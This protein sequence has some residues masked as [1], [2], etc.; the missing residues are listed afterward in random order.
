MKCTVKIIL[1]FLPAFLS[2][3]TCLG[4]ENDIK[5]RIW[6][7]SSQEYIEVI[8][9]TVMLDDGHGPHI[10]YARIKK[11]TL[12]ICSLDILDD[13][14]RVNLYSAKFKIQ[15]LTRDT[16]IIKPINL[17]YTKDYFDDT[18]SILF[19]NKELLV[20]SNLIFQGLK[21]TGSGCLGNCPEYKIDIDANGLL[22]VEVGISKWVKKG[23]YKSQLSNKDLSKLLSILK[24]SNLDS[25]PE[26]LWGAIDAPIYSFEFRY[27]N[28][29]KKSNGSF[30]P[31]FNY[32]L[33]H[34]LYNI[35]SDNKLKR[36]KKRDVFEEANWR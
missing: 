14:D 8:N 13:L 16:L 24:R 11:D 12:K 1:L 5:D 4:Q 2:L 22:Y 32:E 6:V 15:K 17:K 25:F 35:P 34:F 9:D 21:F 3:T 31:Y 18:T 23:N 29:I 19:T 30:I 7:G 20:D 27:N 10:Y 36:T 28:K 33:R 26:N